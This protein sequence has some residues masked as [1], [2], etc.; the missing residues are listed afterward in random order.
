MVAIRV[1][2]RR[3][4]YY[5]IFC[6]DDKDNSEFYKKF[7]KVLDWILNSNEDVV[8]SKDSS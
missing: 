1:R 4:G 3:G 2:D 7:I 6:L 8:V 5:E